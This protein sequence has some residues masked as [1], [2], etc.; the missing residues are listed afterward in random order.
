MGSFRIFG[1]AL[2]TTEI[3]NLAWAQPM[4]AHRYSFTSNAWDSV[5]MAHGTLIGNATV[6]NGALQLTGAAGDYVN[7]PGGLVS[8][9]A[10]VTVEF[11]ATFGVN[12]NYAR[13]FDFGNISGANGSQYVFFSPHTGT[14]AH[15]TE[16]STSSTATF[17]IPGTFDN[18]T[19]HVACVVDPANG[20]TAIFTNG[21]LEKALTNALPVLTGVS[22]NWAFIGRSL[23]SSDAYLNATIDELRIY[24]GRLTPEEIAADYQFGPDTLALPVTVTPSNSPVNLTLSWPSWAV[25]F[26]PETVS[27]LGTGAIWSGVTSSPALGN[28]HWQLALPKTNT[29]QFFRLHR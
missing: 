24:D 23:W 29:A 16:I 7:L 3:K 19:L 17:D 21:V 12:G 20:Y 28:D 2:S 22:K 1:R 27:A 13:M 5:G 4:L 15:R 26:A 18:R 10:A 6:T 25:G 11:W 8:G 14:G 9:S